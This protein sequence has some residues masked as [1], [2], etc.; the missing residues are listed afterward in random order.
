MP[1]SRAI[2]PPRPAARNGRGSLR[3]ASI[4]REGYWDGRLG[5]LSGATHDETGE[6]RHAELGK[7]KGNRDA[8]AERE[9]ELRVGPR[10]DLSRLTRAV[11][12]AIER[13][14]E[15]PLRMIAVL[16]EQ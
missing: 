3:P 6:L 10:L 12:E 8:L 4:A 1:S 13:H 5:R 2:L 15:G 16:R 7:I 9:K 11:G 14:K